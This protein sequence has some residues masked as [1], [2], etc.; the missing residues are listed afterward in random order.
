VM[1][2][3]YPGNLSQ[4]STLPSPRPVV[5]SDTPA[6][7]RTRTSRPRS[8]RKCAAEAPQ[9]PA[10]TTMASANAKA[11][12]ER[13]GG[14]KHIGPHARDPG[15]SGDLRDHRGATAHCR[16]AHET[17]GETSADDGLV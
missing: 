5:P 1:S 4:T 14:V 15:P 8:A 2:R 16:L 3:S 9:M 7:S 10:P 13:V 17:T 12:R 6:R 11:A